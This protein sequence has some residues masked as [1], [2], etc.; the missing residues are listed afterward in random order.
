MYSTQDFRK[1]L[2]IEIDGEPYVIVDFQHVNP[3]KGGAFVR[4]KLK[5]LLSG[6]MTDP[7]FKSGD[8]V[9]KP[10]TSEDE[11]QFLYT[12]GETFNF[13]DVKT[14]EQHAVPAENLGDAPDFLKPE[15]RVTIQF[16]NG[17]AIGIDL[18][19][20]VETR[21]TKCDPG[22][23]GDTV[24]G[25]TKPATVETGA[26]FNVPLFINEGDNIRVDT[27]THGYVSRVD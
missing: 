7:T 9:K 10:D 15:M 23:R 1:G 27:R 25:A 3:G 6:R 5:S 4:T 19:N 18:P 16:Y 17:R 13:M 11:V 12:D 20:F 22:I 26:T 24:G 21:V 14:F 2:K 8:K